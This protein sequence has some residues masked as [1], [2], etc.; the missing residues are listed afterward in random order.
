MPCRINVRSRM[1]E[2]IGESSAQEEA[3][4]ISEKVQ[5]DNVEEIFK[6]VHGAIVHLQKDA[7]EITRYR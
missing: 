6:L 7:N 3:M 5:T 4:N 2:L 1:T